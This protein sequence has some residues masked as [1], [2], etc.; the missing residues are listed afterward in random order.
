MASSTLFR[1]AR[2]EFQGGGD[3]REGVVQAVDEGRAA[4]VAVGLDPGATG[5]AP[6]RGGEFGEDVWAQVVRVEV[7]FACQAGDY[8]FLYTGT[9]VFEVAHQSGGGE[10]QSP[11]GDVAAV[12]VHGQGL[13][14]LGEDVPELGEYGTGEFPLFQCRKVIRPE[15]RLGL[16]GDG[17]LGG[18]GAEEG[19]ARNLG[20]LDQLLHGGG[21]E[22]LLGEQAQ[23][24]VGE[25]AAGA[26]PLAFA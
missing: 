3:C 16:D 22:A 23:G 9:V 4:T 12:P 17:F 24:D 19:A 15:Q 11:G 18:E 8:L 7:E 13:G 6:S 1:A 20:L 26:Q 2:R 14:G 10:D 5:D 21:V 25:G